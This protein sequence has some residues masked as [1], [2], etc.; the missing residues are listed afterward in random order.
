MFRKS[1][2][3]AAAAVPI[4]IA[5]VS[6]SLLK[7]AT[8]ARAA[9][10]KP[11]AAVDSLTVIGHASVKIKTA[12][13]QVIYIDPYQAGNYSDSADVVLITHQHGDHNNQSL[14]KKKKSCTVITNAEALQDGSY[15]SFT[16]GGTGIGAVP[17]YNSNHPKSSSV[18]FV[19]SFNGINLYHAGDTGNIPEM[20][21]LASKNITYALLPMDGIYTMT[22][23]EAVQA[24]AAINAA[25]VIPIHTM[26]PPDTYSDAIVARFTAPNKL[27]V[28][29]GQTIALQP[30]TSVGK[31]PLKPTGFRLDQNYPNPFNP[32]TQ[33][34][35]SL[36]QPSLVNLAVYS[37][38]GAK[39]KTLEDAYK[40]S[41]SHT[42]VW[43]G[44]DSNGAKLGAGVFILEFVTPFFRQSRRMIL[45]K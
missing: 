35:Y 13:N 19:I 41:G 7:P 25:Y 31:S 6:A 8:T 43:D 39:L 9:I 34:S 26:P 28:K 44:T 11:V 2:S 21:N 15:T 32:S 16:I 17:A 37:V 27:V 3:L 40:P 12:Q 5:S 18:G 10:L 22:P 36:T 38:G 14:I 24:A 23:E 29:N 45:V 42:L 30:A 4:L 20:A 33:V 1:I